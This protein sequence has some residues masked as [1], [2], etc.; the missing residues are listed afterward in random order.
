MSHFAQV[1]NGIVRQVIVAEQDFIGTLP[2]KEN[3]I[4]T[5]YNSRSNKH[6]NGDP[7]GENSYQIKSEQPALRA[8]YASVGH[9]YDATHDV[10]YKPQLYPSWVLN[11]AT[12]QW[13]APVPIPDNTN[14][15]HWDETT[16]SWIAA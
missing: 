8:N 10:F 4:Q 13:E 3:W 16:K 6:Y 5:S 15:Y 9:H 7:S 2:D 12:W 11:Q 1:I 14:Y